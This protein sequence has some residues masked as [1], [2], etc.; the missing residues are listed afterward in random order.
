MKRPP[1]QLQPD[2]SWEHDAGQT[3]QPWW[4]R[5]LRPAPLS[6]GLAAAAAAIALVALL[7]ER[8][9]APA[10]ATTPPA[11]ES[12]ASRFAA[13]QEIADAELLSSAADQP[14]AFSDLELA[15]LIGF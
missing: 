10:T 9:A 13:L 6:A 8:P 15:S 1:H 3:R 7:P 5:L 2:D 12:Q 14:D 4:D 11:A